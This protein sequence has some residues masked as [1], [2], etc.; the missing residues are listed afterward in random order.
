MAKIPVYNEGRG[1]TQQTPI[2]ELSRSPNIGAFTAPAKA[3][4]NFADTAGQVAFNFGMAEKE[5]EDKRIVDEEY[6]EA[7]EKLIEH[8]FKDKSTTVEQAKKNFKNIEDKIRNKYKAKNY[9]TRRQNLISQGL[10]KLINSQRFSSMQDS[11]DR[12]QTL[13]ATNSDLIT[14]RQLDALRGLDPTD[15]MFDIV[16]DLAISTVSKASKLSLPTKYNMINL[17]KTIDDIDA[18]NTR[19]GFSE[20][21]KSTNNKKDF[22]TISKQIQGNPKLVAG[23]IDV[24]MNQI[25]TRKKEID[26]ETVVQFG[27]FLPVEE[28][29]KTS[30][31][32]VDG[33][34]ETIFN[35]EKSNKIDDPVLQ[36]KW[37]RA[38]NVQKQKILSEMRGRV[39]QAKDNIVFEQAKKDEIRET[40]NE[41]LLD[42]FM[43]KID[44]GT[45]TIKDV[46]SAKWEGKSGFKIR[47][48]LIDKITDSYFGRINTDSEP[49]I[50]KGIQKKIED[51]EIKSIDTVF[52]LP[53]ESKGIS[54]MDR[55]NITVSRE[56][57]NYFRSLIKDV[58]KAPI[59]L[60]AKEKLDGLKRFEEFL[61]SNKKK[62]QGMY[63]NLNPNAET[64]F[65]YFTVQMRKRFMKQMDAYF[66][67]Q[68]EGKSIEGETLLDFLNPQNKEK[69]ILKDGGAGFFPTTEKV[70]QNFSESLKKKSSVT[71]FNP[72]PK[73][74]GMSAEDYFKSDAYEEW[75][76]SGKYILYIENKKKKGN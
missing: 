28:V 44:N 49:N 36:E 9:G 53:G 12:G 47:D 15:P 55:M 16:K 41:N 13:A 38:D 34:N 56:D 71:D 64:D 24:L 6:N 76:T 73:P 48:T 50:Y 40:N 35:L 23:T 43:E 27:D 5:R 52:Q 14:G 19:S 62:V 21:I 67:R 66:Q 61:A 75:K 31:G 30:F 8:K 63:K 46:K 68:R 72:P 22:D 57:F 10:S 25:K 33:L 39:K 65:Y 4:S 69:Y 37:N 3:L 17:S 26:A 59:N 54:L 20:K 70:M 51:G 42:S 58:A 18:N 29:D 7:A 60:E 45:A 74:D 2:G 32:T 11:F 1:L